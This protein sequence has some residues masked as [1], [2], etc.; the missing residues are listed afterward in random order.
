[1]VKLYCVCVCVCVCVCLGRHSRREVYIAKHFVMCSVWQ[2][3]GHEF[4]TN[5][6]PETSD[7]KNTLQCG[8]VGDCL[9]GSHALP[10][11]VQA[12]QATGRC[13]TGSQSTSWAREWCYI[14][15]FSRVLRDVLSNIGL[16]ARQIRIFWT[17]T[18]GGTNTLLLT[19][20]RHFTVAM[21]MPVRPSATAPPSLYGCSGS[22]WDVLRRFWAL[23]EL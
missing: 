12:S 20:K 14:G 8:I 2:R 16:H 19:T 3:G 18:C 9:V 10:H 13:T 22:W 7:W 23:F 15:T 21:W 4:H 11:G 1:M 17:F 5:M 6:C